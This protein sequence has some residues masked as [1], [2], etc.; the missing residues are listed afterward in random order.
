MR[1]GGKAWATGHI[2]KLQHNHG[3]EIHAEETIGSMAKL[4]VVCES[5]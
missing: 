1:D 2:V 3:D 4:Y 5:D